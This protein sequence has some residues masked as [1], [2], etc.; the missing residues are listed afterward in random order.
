MRLTHTKDT[1]NS[2]TD[3]AGSE[4][5]NLAPKRERHGKPKPTH[6]KQRKLKTVLTWIIAIAAAFGLAI[7][8]RTFIAESFEIPSS[9]MLQ[10]LKVGDRLIG[11]KITYKFSDPKRG[12]IATFNDPEN[13]SITLIKRVIGV[14][15]DTID[16]H[17]GAVYLNGE[18]QYESYTN[19]Q[20]TYPLQ[21]YASFLKGPLS[22]PYTLKEGEYWM[23]GDNRSNS[24]DSRYF[25]PI[26]RKEMT[27]KAWFIFWPFNEDRVF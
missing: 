3:D 20:S 8:T 5:T 11:E 25:G 14:P 26:A 16:I 21:E 27:S 22:Y 18:R 12:D 6:F 9:S 23:M 19:G 1:H 7:F 15:G 13:P 2:A 10:T 4:K 24:L 17:D